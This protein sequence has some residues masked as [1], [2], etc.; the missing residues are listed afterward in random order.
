MTVIFF[1]LDLFYVFKLFVAPYFCRHGEG[2]FGGESSFLREDF[3]H[4]DALA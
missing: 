2:F 3:L 4:E 1:V